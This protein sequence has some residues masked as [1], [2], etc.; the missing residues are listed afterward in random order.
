M[1]LGS[2]MGPARTDMPDQLLGLD[3]A[4]RMLLPGLRATAVSA[5][6]M[7]VD[8]ER[9]FSPVTRLEVRLLSPAFRSSHRHE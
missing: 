7:I 6:G 9:R 3:P 4:W 8:Q 5:A 2:K 1:P